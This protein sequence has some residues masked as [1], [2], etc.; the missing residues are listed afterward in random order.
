M[1]FLYLQPTQDFCQSRM[2]SRI[3]SSS[4]CI[5]NNMLDELSEVAWNVVEVE[6]EELE[7]EEIEE[8]EEGKRNA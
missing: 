4:S 5:P 2:T 6:L 8:I 1:G 7:V 3:M